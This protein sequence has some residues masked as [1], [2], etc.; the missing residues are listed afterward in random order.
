M[1]PLII[2]AFVTPSITKLKSEA[3]G[4]LTL[5]LALAYTSSV[6]SALFA[7]FLGYSFI[8]AL[9]IGIVTE[10]LK[11][12]P[13]LLF[14]LDIPPLMPVMTAFVLS[15]AIGLAVVW[16]GAEKFEQV[17]DEF[18]RMVLAMVNRLLL[19][20]LPFLLRQTLPY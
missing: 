4:I 3:F 8:P 6:G 20:I 13:P 19:P 14:Q 16:T 11:E 7:I 1:V 5:A 15:L 17:L 18:Q 10:G 12:L 2:L 9:N